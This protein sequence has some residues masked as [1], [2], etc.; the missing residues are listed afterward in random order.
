MFELNSVSPYIFVPQSDS[1][2]VSLEMQLPGWDMHLRRTYFP[3]DLCL[4]SR[5][6]D[7]GA[8]AKL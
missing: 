1:Q 6:D 7:C 8:E 5:N 3:T 4:K 2:F